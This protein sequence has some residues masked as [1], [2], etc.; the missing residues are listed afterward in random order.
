LTW[1]KNYLFLWTLFFLFP[2][3]LVLHGLSAMIYRSAVVKVLRRGTIARQDLHPVLQRWLTELR[4]DVIP[5]AETTG[6][7]WFARLTTRWTYRRVLFVVLF[8][9]WF[10]FLFPRAYTGYFLVADP[11]KFFLNHPMVQAPC[12]DFIPPHL[13]TGRDDSTQG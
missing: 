12:F 10:T 6:L 3:W 5:R 9:V 13:W 8:F 4:L 11:F 1:F 2:T 7:G